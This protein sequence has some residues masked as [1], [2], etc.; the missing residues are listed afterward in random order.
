MHAYLEG[1]AHSYRALPPLSVREMMN[2]G[3]GGM[4]KPSHRPLKQVAVERAQVGRESAEKGLFKF[5]GN[6]QWWA[7][8]LKKVTNTFLLVSGPRYM[9]VIGIVVAMSMT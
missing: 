2:L 6:A 3:L 9:T 5:I 4:R 7:P 8:L 1:W